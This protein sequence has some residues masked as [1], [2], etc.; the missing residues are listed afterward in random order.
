MLLWLFGASCC[1]GTGSKLAQP[2]PSASYAAVLTHQL[3]TP[4]FSIATMNAAGSV[5]SN[6]PLDRTCGSALPGALA[7]QAGGTKALIAGLSGLR[8]V[9]C[10]VDLYTGKVLTSTHLAK[11]I[12]VEAAAFDVSTNTTFV[13]GFAM[14][15]GT[16]R[17]SSR[18]PRGTNHIYTWTAQLD[19][20]VSL[21]GITVDI[22]TA[23][24][25]AGQMWVLARDD[26]APSGSALVQ[27]DLQKRKMISNTQ[28]VDLAMMLMW[29]PDT[30]SLLAWGATETDAAVLA[31]LNTTAG[32]FG[33]VFYR[34]KQLSANHMSGAS[35]VFDSQTGVVHSILV[36]GST[37]V[38]VPYSCDVALKTG[39][40][41]VKPSHNFGLAMDVIH[42]EHPYKPE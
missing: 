16:E 25:G 6:M 33:T 11:N 37:G 14:D 32:A 29:K 15:G 42:S 7:V 36:N 9:L 27:V 31:D 1:G 18:G 20:W 12:V 41:T 38:G 10:E 2:R 8:C 13:A 4:Q 3:N 23:V 21:P 19:S 35:S 30:Q 39:E 22:G 28:L 24:I 17:Q 26:N 34:S 5:L 40:A